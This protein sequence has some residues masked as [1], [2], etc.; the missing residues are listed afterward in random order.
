MKFTRERLYQNCHSIFGAVTV[1]LLM[2]GLSILFY[3]IFVAISLF[4]YPLIILLK[5]NIE[6]QKNQLN[7]NIY[8]LNQDTEFSLFFL[9]F[10]YTYTM[11][12]YVLDVCVHIKKKENFIFVS[13]QQHFTTHH[14]VSR[15]NYQSRH[16]LLI[17]DTQPLRYTYP[18]G[19]HMPESLG[20][21]NSYSTHISIHCEI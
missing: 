4:L 8:P 14:I 17:H 9:G 7:G 16:L 15:S 11:A 10:L 19:G 21:I 5:S 2:N 18:F 6:R 20:Q 12:T 13:Q 3:F 1:S